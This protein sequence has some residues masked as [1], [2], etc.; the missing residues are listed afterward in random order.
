MQGRGPSAWEA[1]FRGSLCTG[2]LFKALVC[3]RGCPST[4]LPPPSPPPH[5]SS[6]K[7]GCGLLQR[8]LETDKPSVE[9]QTWGNAL[10]VPTDPCVCPGAR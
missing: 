2:V 4:W 8:V 6:Q 9:S 5:L 7:E 3:V 1:G 10:G